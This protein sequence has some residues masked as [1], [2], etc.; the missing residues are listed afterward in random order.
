MCVSQHHM[1]CTS[2]DFCKFV[3]L[4]FWWRRH[5]QKSFF[6]NIRISYI[7][8]HEHQ[9]SNIFPLLFCDGGG[10]KFFG[11]REI[12]HPHWC[13]AFTIGRSVASSARCTWI[14]ENVLLRKRLLTKSERKVLV[15][16][17]IIEW[18]YSTANTTQDKQK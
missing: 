9:N 5:Q 18:Y 1:M 13:H 10:L 14:Q 4:T 17:K 11:A 6:K 3:F 12:L 7:H 2:T 8:R 16:T 15:S